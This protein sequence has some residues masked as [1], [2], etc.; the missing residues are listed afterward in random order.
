MYKGDKW[1]KWAC[2]A[3]FNGK[4]VLK[5]KRWALFKLRN[6]Y[7]V[8]S[9]LRLNCYKKVVYVFVFVF[10]FEYI[11]KVNVLVFKKGVTYLF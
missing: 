9:K 2:T 1:P 10:V 11:V 8:L 4:C 3:I 6:V 5:T 7:F